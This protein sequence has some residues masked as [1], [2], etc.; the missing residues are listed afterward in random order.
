M[1]ARPEVAGLAEQI[2][3]THLSHPM[4]VAVDGITAAGKTTFADG[5]C[6]AVQSLGRSAIRLSTDDFHHVAAVRHR[7]PDRA[8]GYYRD[9]YDFDTFR[10][11]VL[12]PLGPGG[13]RHYRPRSHDLDTDA[14]LDEP[15]L[16]L[17]RD[18]VVVVDGS[19][20][21]SAPLAGGWDVVVWLDTSF[22]VALERGVRRDADRLG[23]VDA[24]RAAF[25]DRYHAANRLYL[26]E[27]DPRAS[28]TII[29]DA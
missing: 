7:D 13:D 20:L 25:A 18:A 4:R 8:H 14:V 27:V 2:A 10:R 23:G 29:V 15:P 22:A 26:D 6:S 3:D 11:V 9:A 17:T 21:Q 1:S 5:L 24:A 28:A 19:F 12:D 16:T